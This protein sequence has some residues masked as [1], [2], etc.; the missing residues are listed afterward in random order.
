[1]ALLEGMIAK[2]QTKQIV[3]NLGS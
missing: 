2:Y 1:K 3:G